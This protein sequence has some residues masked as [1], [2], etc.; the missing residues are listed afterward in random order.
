MDAAAAHAY[1]GAYGVDAVVEALHGYL[2]ALAWDACYLAN[3]DDAFGNLGHLGLEQALQEHGACA[4]ENDLGVAGAVVH[5][6]DDGT[7]GFALTEEVAGDLLA[8]GQQQLV[9]FLVEQQHFLVPYLVDLGR[10]DVAYHVLV[11]VVEGVV[12]QLEDARGE[13]L[14]QRQ[15]GA[16]A[17]LREV[18]G[19]RHV[20]AHFVVVGNL[21]CLAQADL[22]VG[23][24]DLVV[25]DDGAVA[26]DFEV[27]LVGVYDDVVVLVRALHFGYD[28]AEALFEH[29]H[30]RGAVDVLCLFELCEGVD[31]SVGLFLCHY[32]N[33]MILRF[34]I[35]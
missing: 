10:D 17:E 2:C 6:R 23:V 25:L 27:A 22:H 26:V 33:F 14:A 30:E 8:L 21:A 4:R 12:L 35:L 18:D 5:A 13:G 31:E 7:R 16:A 9:A 3:G 1:T 32:L 20:L 28:V 19:L 24:F 34:Y 29:A 15:Y 11:L